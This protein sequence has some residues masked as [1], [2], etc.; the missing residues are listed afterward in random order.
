M[1]IC[2]ACHLGES[3]P[4]QDDHAPSSLEASV[5]FWR[6]GLEDVRQSAQDITYSGCRARPTEVSG[7]AFGLRVLGGWAGHGAARR[8]RRGRTLAGTLSGTPRRASASSTPPLHRLLPP[9]VRL[10]HSG[11]PGIL[12]SIGQLLQSGSGSGEILVFALTS[13]PKVKLVSCGNAGLRVRD[14]ECVTLIV[15]VG[16]A[17]AGKIS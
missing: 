6:Q 12:G 11:G 13:L 17:G 8:Q 9:R 10:C 2:L 16:G 4:I 1:N 3:R 15:C 7:G 5:V 14:T